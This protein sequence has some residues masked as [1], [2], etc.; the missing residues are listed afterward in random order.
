[1]TKMNEAFAVV[2][3][4]NHHA[5]ENINKPTLSFWQDAWRRLKKNKVAVVSMWLLIG[6]LLFAMVSSFFVSQNQANAFN[7]NEVTRYKN[8]PPNVGLPIPGWNGQSKQPGAS[9]TTN[10]YE[11]N[12]VSQHYIFGTDTLGRSI[13]KRVVVGLR[14]SLLV[15]IAATFIDLLIGVSYGVFSAWRGGWVDMVMQRIIEIISSIP[16]LVVVTMLALVLGSGVTSIIIAIALTNWVNMARLVRSMTLSLKEQDFVLAAQNLGESPVKIALKHLIP[17][18]TGTI[19]VQIMMTVPSAII[20]EA[21][22]SAIGLGVKPP[23]A[24]LGSL[25]SDAQNMLQ[26]YPYQILIPSAILVIV[27]LAFILLGDG[28]RDAFDPRSSEE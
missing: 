9:D 26:F 10:P 14:I 4:L 8:L 18:M 24:S 27:S 23:T 2:G 7:T 15:A 22:L 1:M 6:M 21:V 16:N 17:N 3:I 28:L 25:I 20:F 5:G 12:D 11:Q 13:A 19:I